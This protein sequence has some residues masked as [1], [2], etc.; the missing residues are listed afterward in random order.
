MDCGPLL[1]E[2]VVFWITCVFS[3]NMWSYEG[4]VVFC[5]KCG[6]LSVVWYSCWKC[7]GVGEM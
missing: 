7:G 2:I 6:R 5:K 4:S 3:L 1:L